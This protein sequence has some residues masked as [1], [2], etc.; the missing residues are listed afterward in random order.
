MNTPNASE[1][2]QKQSITIRMDRDLY[3]T[4]KELARQERRSMSQ[5]IQ[6]LAEKGAANAHR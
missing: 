6:V 3:D 1:S 2:T 4:I 5:M